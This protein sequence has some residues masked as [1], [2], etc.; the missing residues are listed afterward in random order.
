[1]GRATITSEAGDGRYTI[2]VDF[3]A[4]E[5]ARRLDRVAMRL[6]EL[7]LRKTWQADI[8]TDLEDG[9]PSLQAELDALIA[10]YVAASKAVPRD[11]QNEAAIKKQIDAKTAD[12]AKQRT[13]I[14]QA[15][16]ALSLTELQIKA[17][18]L[19]RGT[20]EQLAVTATQGAW[21]AD[22]TEQATGSVATL[23]IPG[24]SD[25]ILIKPGAPAPVAADGA[26]V[27]REMQTPE[28]VFWNAAVLPGWQKHL[29]TYRWGTI[30]AIDL[31]ADTCDLD[32]APAR[33][34]AQG[35]D[36]NQSTAL[37][38]V[39]VVYM[40]CNAAAF[41]IGSRVVVEFI[42]QDWTRPRVIG[43]VDHPRACGGAGL[44]CIPANDAAPYGWA[45]PVTD[46]DGNP[47]NDG[48]G[49]VAVLGDALAPPG[50][51]RDGTNRTAGTLASVTAGGLGTRTLRGVRA[52]ASG[53]P[54]SG[55][56]EIGNDD[57]PLSFSSIGRQSFEW[58]SKTGATIATAFGT[59]RVNGRDIGRPELGAP[60]RVFVP[61]TTV[62][63]GTPTAFCVTAQGSTFRLYSRPLAGDASL[64]WTFVALYDV[65]T[66]TPALTTENIK[67]IITNDDASVVTLWFADGLI[68][69][70]CLDFAI[71]GGAATWTP[72]VVTFSNDY[73]K[74][75][76]VNYYP[77]TIVDTFSTQ[78]SVDYVDNAKAF[79]TL[80]ATK[81]D[82][83]SATDGAQRI[84]ETITAD[85]WGTEV[86]ISH[87]LS[88]YESTQEEWT[89]GD[90]VDRLRT[91]AARYVSQQSRNVYFYGGAGD[92]ILFTFKH[93]ERTKTYSSHYEDAWLY[94]LCTP[95]DTACFARMGRDEQ[96]TIPAISYGVGMI[97]G[98]VETLF[99]DLS[100]PAFDARLQLENDYTLPAKAE[101]EFGRFYYTWT[102]GEWFRIQRA[103]PGGGYWAE[104]I[105]T[106]AD[107]ARRFGTLFV[108]STPPP[109]FDAGYHWTATA[110]QD[111]NL[112][113]FNG[114]AILSNPA[115]AES[116]LDFRTEGV[117]AWG[118]NWP[119][120]S[121]P[122][123]PDAEIVIDP[124]QWQ[125][126]C[127]DSSALARYAIDLSLTPSS[128]RLKYLQLAATS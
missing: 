124:T 78:I 60:Y 84:E 8:L 69:F 112:R 91:D 88:E 108:P 54:A 117:E 77:E 102:A 99:S 45:P 35:L 23:E 96:W 93:H 16:N 80:T 66:L 4:A 62:T 29:P 33:S 27:A 89:D 76:P 1:M 65:A 122:M 111:V 22:L 6:Y 97:H 95:G 51:L 72:A 53:I 116:E 109:F 36:V 100:R 103:T 125:T 90:G 32:L 24:E 114:F 64:A 115:A 37:A 17:A 46:G 83:L 75:Y 104:G 120:K 74:T 19:E 94:G 42:N 40:T 39:P 50:V 15:R 48:K 121:T 12:I 79:A 55:P 47:I 41:E 87:F 126:W 10:A 71:P 106:F 18:E 56:T 30:T 92:P 67:K 13:L 26:L 44:Y 70:G 105:G 119:P 101:G 38:N 73:D 63:A 127:S 59:C 3:G 20:L 14:L 98:G 82:Y 86:E 7:G 52:D 58:V 43:F 123:P 49:A 11:A 57:D 81:T 5:K 113:C 31:G 34:S 107:V 9:L 2:E 110:L 28:Q 85:F 68:G 25:L 128:N 118:L 61:A 21:C